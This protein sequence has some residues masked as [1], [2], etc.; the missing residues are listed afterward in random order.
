MLPIHPSLPCLMPNSCYCISSLAF[1][2]RVKPGRGQHSSFLRISRM[3]WSRVAPTI[4]SLS[5]SWCFTPLLDESQWSRLRFILWAPFS[6]QLR[7][8]AWFPLRWDLHSAVQRF[9]SPSCRSLPL[10]KQYPSSCSPPR[11]IS[12][13]FTPPKHSSERGRLPRFLSP[14]S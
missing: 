6:W 1:T 5:C 9:Y 3:F 2:D 10:C 14:K 8:L 7:T 13:V 11:H 4:W 12:P